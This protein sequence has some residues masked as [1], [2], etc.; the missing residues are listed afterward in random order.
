M[1][2]PATHFHTVTSSSSLFFFPTKSNTK[3][4]DPTKFV[5]RC[6]DSETRTVPDSAIQRIADKLRSLG[7]ADHQ[8][9]ASIPSTATAAGEIFV[10]L[11]HQLPKQRV[12]HT[13]D[14]S[15]STLENPVPGKGFA[16]LSENEVEKQRRQNEKETEER[17]KGGRRVEAPTVAELSLTEAEIMRLRK[18]GFGMKKKLKVGKAGITEG[19]VNGIHERWRSHEVVKIVCE[20]LCRTNMKRTHDLLEVTKTK[21][22]V[23]EIG[24]TL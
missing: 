18:L 13:I 23:L 20:D 22:L 12:G 24:I 11:P 6:S 2:L 4:L 5:I 10:P 16:A 8:S 19:I 14:Q 3:T 21:K 7:I 15:W 1:L 9:P 17:R